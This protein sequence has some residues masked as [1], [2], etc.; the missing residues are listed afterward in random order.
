MSIVR[1][2][3]VV[4][5]CVALVL[6]LLSTSSLG[7]VPPAARATEPATGAAVA[8]SPGGRFVPLATPARLVDTGTTNR[9]QPRATVVSALAGRGGLPASGVAAVSAHIAVQT[10]TAAGSMRAWATGKPNPAVST[11][12]FEQNMPWASTHAVVEVSATGEASFYNNSTGTV[13]LVVDVTGY[14]LTTAQPGGQVFVPLP[15]GRLYATPSAVAANATVTFPVAGTGG[16]PAASS[17]GAVLLNITAA[18]PAAAGSWRVH[19]PGA[20]P[21]F[22]YGHYVAGRYKANT[23]ITRLPADGRLSLQNV[24]SGTTRYVIDVLGYYRVPTATAAGDR[25]YPVHPSR[26]LNTATPVAAG[27][28][29]NVQVTDRG[30]VPATG[31]TSVAL[32]V[33]ARSGTANGSLIVF[34]AGTTRPGI[35]HLPYPVSGYGFNLVW[36]K[37]GASGQVSIYN[38]STGTVLLYADVQAYALAPV[39][40]SPPTQVAAAAGDRAATVSW[41]ASNDGGAPISRYTVTAFPGGAT[42]TSTT[43]SATVTGLINGTPYTFTVTATNL[44]GTSAASAPS[45]DALP[46]P[47]MRPGRPL[48]TEVFPR[49]SAARVTWSPPEGG[50]AGLTKYVITTSPGGATMDAPASA[51]DTIV[52]GLT[53]GSPYSFTV[54]AVNGNGAGPASPPS[55]PVRPRPATAPVKPLVTAV[56]ALNQRVDVQWAPAVDGGAPVTGY[57]VTAQPGG[58]TVNTQPDTTVASLTGLANGTAYTVSV[59]A[60]NKAGSSPAGTGGPVTP[61]AARPPAAPTDLHAGVTAAG[62]VKLSWT[63]PIDVGT[64]PISAYTVTATAGTTSRTVNSTTPSATVTSL[65]TDTS[66]VFT[67]KAANSHGAGPASAATEPVSPKLTVK[68]TPKVLSSAALRTLR[69]AHGDGTLDFEQP[70]AEVTGLTAGTIIVVNP[71][72]KAPRGLLRKVTSVTSQSGLVVVTT[73]HAGLDEVLGDGSISVAERMT[74]ADV[75][76]FTPASAGVRV[77]EPMID[78]RT[79]SQ[80]ARAG[81]TSQDD[82]IGVHD[83]GFAVEFQK[84]FGN[85]GKL[86]ATL[87]LEPILNATIAVSGPNIATH[88]EVG[89]RGTAHAGGVTVGMSGTVGAEV[90]LKTFPIGS[91]GGW[92]FTVQAGPVPVVMCPQIDI[93]AKIEFEG[94]VGVHFSAEYARVL[95]GEAT[96]NNGA[97]TDFHFNNEVESADAPGITPYAE[98]TAE[99]GIGIAAVL[100]FYDLAGPGIELTPYVAVDIDHEAHP[101]WEIS[102]GIKASFILRLKLFKIVEITQE[103]ELADISV[104]VKRAI[105]TFEGIKISPP[106][107]NIATGASTMF[108]AT[109]DGVGVPVRWSVESGPG[110]INQTGGFT[111]TEPGWAVVKAVPTDPNLMPATAAVWI[112]TIPSDPKPAVA[113]A[114]LSVRVTWDAVTPGDSPVTHYAI[115]TSP[116]TATT[117]IEADPARTTYTEYARGLKAGVAYRVQVEALTSGMFG[118][119]SNWVGPAVPYPVISRIGSP[120]DVAT[121]PFGNPDSTGKAGYWGTAVSGNGRY[122]FFTTEARSNLAPPEIYNPTSSTHYLLRRDL[123]TGEIILASRR[124]DGRTPA[125]V[126]PT[127]LW[128]NFSPSFDGNIVTFQIPRTGSGDPVL[129]HDIAARTT[130]VATSAANEAN[131]PVEPVLSGNG[132]V[133][134]FTVSTSTPGEVTLWRTQRNGSPQNITGC[135]APIDPCYWDRAAPYTLSPDGSRVVYTI[136]KTDTGGN[137]AVPV[138]WEGGRLINLMTN[139]RWDEFHLTA[140]DAILSPDGTKVATF[141]DSETWNGTPDDLGYSGIAVTPI[142][143]RTISEPDLVA[144]TD[145]LDWHTYYYRPFDITTNGRLVLYDTWQQHPVT[146]PAQ[147]FIA[148]SGSRTSQHIPQTGAQGSLQLSDDG[149][150]FVWAQYCDETYP[151]RPGVRSGVYAQRLG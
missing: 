62:S 4:V 60:R 23:M 66:W 67:V 48:V 44:A 115:S 15:T 53:N 125:T 112:G 12:T 37:V 64:A 39:K 1:R 88:V 57:T 79:R 72:E 99:F 100:Y 3:G 89:A 19:W 123:T 97:V 119:I 102:V 5:L 33:T 93:T 121:D 98:G 70:P 109:H 45:N 114:P 71:N 38:S 31:V 77:R 91:I 116:P 108:T 144:R 151:C 126:V 94:T 76:T 138:L 90:G 55:T 21:Q 47:P 10:P 61:N 145:H 133:V 150:M 11:L 69:Q 28:T 86:D 82:P 49:D 136:R 7:A 105:G 128:T 140:E 22:G 63:P 113:A 129:V 107:I 118:S 18:A 26:L 29:L 52:T 146:T 83:S 46:A 25:V 2:L 95:T 84:E 148:N 73:E 20:Q 56:T 137:L 65:A 14:Y 54:T 27:G 134:L 34:P 85:G 9:V 58:H 68:A 104:S 131:S 8:G 80:G 120:A 87:S 17:I 42:A 13:R 103:W 74:A 141:H 35:G 142:T 106:G 43:T 78:G 75:Q 147:L 117:Y 124:E 132:N 6:P 111:S 101:W 41:Q 96:T 36:A 139:A 40:P 59:V 149:R 16:L 127:P 130:W 24:S 122:V 143:A 135:A 50:A 92:C 30:G 51:T 110:T 81:A 32:L